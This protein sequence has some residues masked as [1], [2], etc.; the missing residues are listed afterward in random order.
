MTPKTLI[1]WAISIGVISLSIILVL[2]IRWDFY[3]ASFPRLESLL[4]IEN[5]RIEAILLLSI[6]AIIATLVI[7]LFGGARA[8][9]TFKALGVQLEGPAAPSV[10]WA[11]VFT[12]SAVCLNVISS[13]IAMSEKTKHRTLSAEQALQ[14]ATIVCSGLDPD[15]GAKYKSIDD[16]RD[17]LRDEHDLAVYQAYIDCIEKMTNTL[18]N[19]PNQ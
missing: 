18:K 3:H 6:A 16:V 13:S 19:E 10:L 14:Q 17:K 8:Q 2:A 11:V 9:L 12:I 5:P 15:G 4:G 1:G 7:Y